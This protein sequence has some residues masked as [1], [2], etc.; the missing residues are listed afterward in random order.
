M[1]MPQG[2]SEK[3][4]LITGGGGFVGL[5]LSQELIRRGYNVT[6]LDIK[7]LYDKAL[8]REE[9]DKITRIEVYCTMLLS[10]LP[11]HLVA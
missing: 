5:K 7:F 8:A 6:A 1:S 11:L 2:S 10:N 9:D 3:R 4:V